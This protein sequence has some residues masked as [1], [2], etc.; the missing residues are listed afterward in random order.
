[1]EWGSGG[2]WGFLAMSALRRP[3]EAGSKPLS[4]PVAP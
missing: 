1:M 3:L 2:E 4:Q